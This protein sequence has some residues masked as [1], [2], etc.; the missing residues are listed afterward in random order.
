MN[1]QLTGLRWKGVMGPIVVLAMVLAACGGSSSTS[2][3]DGG[4]SSESTEAPSSDTTTGPPATTD[5]EESGPQDGGVLRVTHATQVSSLDPQIGTSGLDYRVLY[6]MY[7]RLVNVTD[8]TME[9]VPGLAESWEFTSPTT[10]VLNLEQGVLFH[11]GTPFNA[12]AVKYNIERGQTVEDS[13]VAV[14]LANVDTVEVI[15]EFTVQLNLSAPDTALPLKLSDRGGMMISPTAAEELGEEL[16]NHAV[17]TGPFLVSSYTPGEVLEVVRFDDYW[18]VDA[19]HLDGITFTVISDS[20]TALNAVI[21][22]EQDAATAIDIEEYSRAEEADDVTPIASN[23]LAYQRC[24]F[25]LGEPPFDNVLVRQAMN[26][27]FDRNALN[28]VVN[29]GIGEGSYFAVPRTHWSY[30]SSLDAPFDYNPDRA[31]ELLAEAG[32]PDGIEIELITA[33]VAPYPKTAEVLQAQL[34]ESGITAEI[35][36][37]EAIEAITAFREN[38]E[39]DLLCIGW[40]GRPD[41]YQ[42]LSLNYLSESPSVTDYEEPDDLQTLLAATIESTSLEERTAAFEDLFQ[43]ITVDETLDMNLIS[44]PSVSVHADTVQNLVVGLSGHPLFSEVRLDN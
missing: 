10:L 32:Y 25:R 27:A 44:I 8:D 6:T 9:P 1:K 2:T 7:D 22:G 41:P 43:V 34:S 11:D 16:G 17:G 28:E 29:L 20:R 26:H 31:R 36:A 35:V 13:R 39:G 37:I 15:D 23:G 33:N 18:R 14:D 5:Q 19:I 4:A 30:P 12:E 24:A 3:T 38:G 42:T 40:S 21:S